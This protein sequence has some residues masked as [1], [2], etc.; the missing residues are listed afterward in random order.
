MMMPLLEDLLFFV[1]I[2]AG[3][4]AISFLFGLGLRYFNR[5]RNIKWR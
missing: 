1:K 2:L 3:G 5:V 4:F